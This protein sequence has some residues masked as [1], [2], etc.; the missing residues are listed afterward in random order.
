MRDL[1]DFLFSKREDPNSKT[2]PYQTKSPIVNKREFDYGSQQD[3][4]SS[5]VIDVR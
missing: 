3:E 1:T 4:S 5:V 2:M